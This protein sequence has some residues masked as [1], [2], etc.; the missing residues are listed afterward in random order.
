LNN[1]PVGSAIL[2]GQT[3]SQSGLSST[4]WNWPTWQRRSVSATAVPPA[5]LPAIPFFPTTRAKLKP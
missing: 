4:I 1:R 5:V 2:V 3:D